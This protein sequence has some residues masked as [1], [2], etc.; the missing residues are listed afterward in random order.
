MKEKKKK[1]FMC[2][3]YEAFLPLSIFLNEKNSSS[4]LHFFAG[5]ILFIMLRNVCFVVVYEHQRT[6]EE[7]KLNEN[8]IERDFNELRYVMAQ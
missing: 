2:S 5:K 1:A 4:N 3:V 8:K 7:K 6:G